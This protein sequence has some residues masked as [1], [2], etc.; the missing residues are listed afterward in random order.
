WATA[1]EISDIL[2]RERTKFGFA[3]DERGKFFAMASEI[4]ARRH[5][6]IRRSYLDLTDAEL[7]S[8]FFE[9]EDRLAILQRLGAMRQ[10]G[11]YKKLKKHNVLNIVAKANGEYEL[12]VEVFR[13][14]QDAI[15]RANGLEAL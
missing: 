11:Q 10:F 12:E 2:D 3:E 5:E 6:G 15:Q 14:A 13:N 7:E 1:L 4:I 9:A 8:L